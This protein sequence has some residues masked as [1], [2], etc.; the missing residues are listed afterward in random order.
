MTDIWRL[1]SC[2]L[3]PSLHKTMELQSKPAA[4]MGPVPNQTPEE[5]TLGPACSQSTVQTCF[6]SMGAWHHL[7]N[8]GLVLVSGTPP[9]PHWGWRHNRK[10]YTL[11]ECLSPSV[12]YKNRWAP[13]SPGLS[14]NRPEQSFKH[15][16]GKPIMTTSG[17]IWLSVGRVMAQRETE[18]L[19][20]KKDLL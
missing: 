7:G 18:T 3:H 13:T 9:M 15:Y 20:N 12:Y 1:Q 14:K 10:N 16:P 4:R 8:P 5:F 19:G 17:S 2:F 11:Y 6:F